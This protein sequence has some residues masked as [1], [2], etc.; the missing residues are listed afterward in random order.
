M[1]KGK[2][3]Y[4]M[5]PD[6]VISV[7]MIPLTANGKI[8]RKALPTLQQIL[9]DS[10]A[11]LSTSASP[12]ADDTAV[13]LMRLFARVLGVDDK[14]TMSLTETFMNQG[15]H[16]LILLVF[17]NLVL[18]ETDYKISMKDILLHPTIESLAGYIDSICA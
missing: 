1:L 15:G 17:H 14:D 11:N 6:L 13:C 8:N 9:R 10:T 7:P 12:F 3:P 4:Y 18:R 16:S 5:L 2:L